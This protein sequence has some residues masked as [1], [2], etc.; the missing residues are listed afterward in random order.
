MTIDLE[1]LNFLMICG[2]CGSEFKRSGR[3]FCAVC[4]WESD[5]GNRSAM[6]LL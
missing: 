5:L 4:E 1:L 2:R 3:K 6:K